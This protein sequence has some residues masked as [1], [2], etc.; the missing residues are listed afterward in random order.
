MFKT[1][2]FAIFIFFIGAANVCASEQLYSGIGGDGHLSVNYKKDGVKGAYLSSDSS[3]LGAAYGGES[4]LGLEQE[5][6]ISFYFKPDTKIHPELLR[7]YRMK[8][9]IFFTGTVGVFN[10]GIN[11]I[12]NGFKAYININKKDGRQTLVVKTASSRNLN[13][14]SRWLSGGTPIENEK[15]YHLVIS[16]K[17]SEAN[18]FLDG[19]RVGQASNFVAPDFQK[20]QF[21][22]LGYVNPAFNLCGGIDEFKI[23]QRG[24]QN[25]NKIKSW[26]NANKYCVFHAS[27]ENSLEASGS[28]SAL[29]N[30]TVYGRIS[31][32]LETLN[33]AHSNKKNRFYV[34]LLN[35]SDK[36]L[37]YSL[38]AIFEPVKVKGQAYAMSH[39]IRI[40]SVTV[41]LQGIVKKQKH[42]VIPE[43]VSFK[44]NWLYR[45]FLR[46][47][48]GDKIINAE[49]TPIAVSQKPL[50]INLA[51]VTKSRVEGCSRQQGLR[52]SPMSGIKMERFWVSWRDIE[53]TKGQYDWSKMDQFLKEAEMTGVKLVPALWRIPT[54]ASTAPKERPERYQKLSLNDWNEVIAYKYLPDLKAL[55]KFACD[56][57]TRYKGKIKYYEFWNEPNATLKNQTS[58]YVKALNIYAKAIKRGN[59][60]AVI[61]GISGA[62]GFVGYTD[63]ILSEKAFEAFDIHAGHY[64]FNSKDPLKAIP[65]NNVPLIKNIIKVLKSHNMNVPLWGTESGIGHAKRELFRPYSLDEVVKRQAEKKQVKH[66]GGVSIVSEFR[67]SVMKTRHWINLF[68]NGV[69]KN[70]SWI[71]GFHRNF[72][73]NIAY[74]PLISTV[75]CSKL[76]YGTET[77]AER[78][79]LGSDNYYC[80][81][82]KKGK[83]YFYTFHS[84]GKEGMVKLVL[85]DAPSEMYASD[86]FGNR[87]SLNVKGKT[88][89]MPLK[90]EPVFLF[91][92]SLIQIDN[93]LRAANSFNIT[94]G[95]TKELPITICNE[96]LDNLQAQIVVNSD[97]ASLL[98]SPASNKVLLSKGKSKKIFFNLKLNKSVKA[99]KIKLTVKVIAEKETVSEKEIEI[100][101]LNPETMLNLVE[102]NSNI[103]LDGTLNDWNTDK[104]KNFTFYE[105]MVIGKLS[106]MER[107]V[108]KEKERWKGSKDLH[109]DF[110]LVYSDNNLYGAIRVI[111]DKVSVN[112][113]T[114]YDGDGI[115]IFID[116][117]KKD[118]QGSAYT[119]K[120]CIQL[121][122][123]P[124]GKEGS[125]LGIKSG[126]ASI[127]QG[128][129]YVY[130]LTKNGYN[131]EFKIPLDPKIF[132]GLSEYSETYSLGFDIGLDDCDI[133]NL[134][135]RDNRKVQMMWAGNTKNYADASKYG[136][137][138][139]HR[140]RKNIIKNGDFEDK[141]IK[142]PSNKMYKLIRHNGKISQ[143]NFRAKKQLMLKRFL[144]KIEKASDPAR[145]KIIKTTCSDTEF[146]KKKFPI[147]FVIYQNNIK[148]EGSY[149][150]SFDVKTDLKAV[151]K[152]FV[153]AFSYNIHTMYKDAK[154]GLNLGKDIN[155][156]SG[157]SA[158]KK[159]S[160]VY[161][162]PPGTVQVNI[163]F[164][165]KGCVGSFSVD[166]ISFN[167]L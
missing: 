51:S 148:K 58:G 52:Y 96:Y 69:Q 116:G 76:F 136:K 152:S 163:R 3:V 100:N 27:F 13:G 38:E 2:G 154:H 117:R 127:P 164:F 139:L 22:R 53:G 108:F 120:G 105:N 28:S 101:V 70:F 161:N 88:I 37:D 151:D 29:K 65:E 149:E 63:N 166:N 32:P 39:G 21:I 114:F 80:Y 25:F 132:I 110:S 118:S 119:G 89:I 112:S 59:H 133:A 165:M 33:A 40:P 87:L 91:T 5:G 111:D 14:K 74:M 81:R 18:V 162:L 113:K 78:I 156:I 159:V 90:E 61:V 106:E 146:A 123:P 79:T 103:V 153:N 62:P 83:N 115:E 124:F 102:V 94:A 167:R 86:H 77:F 19:K 95:E 144:L 98:V 56:M 54:W 24:S 73:D 10:P 46:G 31:F 43:T 85:S 150:L 68:G 135:A 137:L 26:L 121:F 107:V 64:Y 145:G 60:D 48:V 12:D 84:N 57:A 147:G 75:F 142:L 138:L 15:W 93:I 49:N 17:G 6:T 45:C 160:F 126:A 20:I 99:R 41:K 122:L 55:D 66:V 44:K 140:K 141:T 1:T 8:R 36:D 16:W 11:L 131:I 67:A 155:F 134:Q 35:G 158:W 92:S 128:S 97:N 47:K 125:I 143:S 4:L 7:S 72:M 30:D 130:R 104:F 157:V 34:H 71:P 50:D 109:G 82:F 42:N 23:L 9:G 129:V